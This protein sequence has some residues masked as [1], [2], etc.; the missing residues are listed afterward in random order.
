MQ[1][2]SG[3]KFLSAK[4]CN[5]GDILT[6]KNAGEYV[7]GKWVHP[8]KK[9]DGTPHPMAGKPKKELR[10]NVDVNGS[11]F[12]FTA[13]NTNQIILKEAYGND[14][15]KWV[16]RKCGITI[17]KVNVGGQVKDS[18]M[19]TPT[20]GQSPTTIINKGDDWDN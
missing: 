4:T 19:L 11:E 1:L 7:D 17:V 9:M 5:T 20:K 18:V 2:Q 10:F 6:F 3:G 15:D 16:G 14:T 12:I 13:N 8:D